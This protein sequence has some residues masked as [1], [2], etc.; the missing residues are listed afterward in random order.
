MVSLGLRGIVRYDTV[1]QLGILAT[2]VR[3]AT[4]TALTG[5]TSPLIN[6]ALFKTLPFLCAS[7]IV[8]AT[9]MT[10]LSEMGGLARHR[11]IVTAA[12]LLGVASPMHADR[13]G[14]VPGSSCE[15]TAR[16]Q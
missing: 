1:S 14:R 3:T 10:K 4:F 2:A 13:P 12:F 9:G 8:H 5:L 6:H 7:A 11:P 16:R 15:S